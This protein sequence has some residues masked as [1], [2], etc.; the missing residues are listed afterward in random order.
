MVLLLV[1]NLKVNSII[2]GPTLLGAITSIY[3]VVIR[4]Q[5]VLM[6]D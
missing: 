5:T 6:S 3:D 2:E 4:S 1:N